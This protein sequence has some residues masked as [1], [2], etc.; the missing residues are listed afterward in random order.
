MTIR[1]RIDRAKQQESLKVEDLALLLNY[2]PVSIYRL[3]GRGKIPGMFR[4]GR[5]LRFKTRII[6]A[7]GERLD[8]RARPQ[9]TS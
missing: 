3:A 1:E 6:L 5:S 2:H 4:V 8:R 7:W 9:P